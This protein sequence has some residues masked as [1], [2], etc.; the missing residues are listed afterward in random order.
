MGPPFPTP[1]YFSGFLANSVLAVKQSSPT[2]ERGRRTCPNSRSL[3]RILR[4]TGTV[5]NS[6]FT[7]RDYR[8]IVT[9]GEFAEPVIGWVHTTDACAVKSLAVPFNTR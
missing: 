2:F 5:R 1:R 7:S 4:S 8:L 3:G 6:G 9:S